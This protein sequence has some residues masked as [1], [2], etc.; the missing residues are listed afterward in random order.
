MRSKK[1]LDYDDLLK[2]YKYISLGYTMKKI[3]QL[4]GKNRSTIYR[5]II[6]NSKLEK[7]STSHLLSNSKF[8]NCCNLLNCKRNGILCC[9]SNCPHFKKWTCPKLKSFPYICN[10]CENRYQCK[11]EKR[12]FN[13]EEAYIL[14]EDRLSESKTIPDVNKK[15]LEK[16]NEWVSP[17]IKEGLSVEAIYSSLGDMFPASSRTVRNWINKGYLDAK[18]IDLRNA[19]KREYSNREYLKI[20]FLR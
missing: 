17:L 18:R 9:P 8:K 15:D 16:F 7:G 2:I 13:P 3:V 20:R 4:T 1:H 10:F 5:L 11:R 12:I 6:N 14:R 19:V